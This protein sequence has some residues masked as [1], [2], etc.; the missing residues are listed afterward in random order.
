MHINQIMKNLVL[1][2]SVLFLVSCN[3]TDENINEEQFI[4][5]TLAIFE[6]LKEYYPAEDVNVLFSE[7]D[8]N[9]YQTATFRLTGK[10]RELVKLGNFAGKNK[11]NNSGGTTCHT[12]LSCGREIKEC[13]DNGKDALISNGACKDAAWCVECLD[14]D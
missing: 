10:T 12:K 3:N 2:I 14:V 4:E 5:H 8:S 1:L 11:V 6:N 9:G 13:L 7:I